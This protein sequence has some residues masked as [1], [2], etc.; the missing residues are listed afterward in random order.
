VRSVERSAAVPPAGV[1]RP[2]IAPHFATE[3]LSKGKVAAPA[4]AA[5]DVGKGAARAEATESSPGAGAELL[6]RGLDFFPG[7]NHDGDRRKKR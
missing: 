5:D 6:Q 3:S 7:P 2:L 1:P 4:S